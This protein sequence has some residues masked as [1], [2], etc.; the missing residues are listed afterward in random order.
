MA[1]P[2]FVD[3]NVDLSSDAPDPEPRDDEPD[4][5]QEPA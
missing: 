4:P 3:W 1:E 2:V 5:D